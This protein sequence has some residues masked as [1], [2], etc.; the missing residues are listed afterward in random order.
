MRRAWPVEFGHGLAE[1]GTHH[2]RRFVNRM[3][4]S[5]VLSL[6]TAP[7]NER[8]WFDLVRQHVSSLRY[9]TVQIVVHDSHVTQVEK[10]ERVRFERQQSDSY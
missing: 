9:G 8:D 10:T 4:K 3:S 2:D 1:P 5:A 6:P 7:S